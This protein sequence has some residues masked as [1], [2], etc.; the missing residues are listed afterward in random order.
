[1]IFGIGGTF[2]VGIGSL[3]LGLVLMVAWR[4]AP[5]SR[6]FFRG[7]SLNEDTAV[8]VP[9]SPETYKR[10]VDGGLA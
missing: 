4:F 2:V 9:D 10:S 1:M 6:A 7:E 8:L 3:A 5:R